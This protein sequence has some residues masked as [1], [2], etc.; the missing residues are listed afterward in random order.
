MPYLAVLLSTILEQFVASVGVPKIESFSYRSLSV[1]QTQQG[2]LTA[3]A[4]VYF[5]APDR[6]REDS[7]M[8]FGQ[9]VTIRRGDESWAETPRGVSQ[10]TPDQH[11]RTVERLYRNYLGLLW[12]AA[13]GRVEVEEPDSGELVLR[14]EGLEMHASFDDDTGHLLEISMLGSNLGG[15]PVTEKRV[16]SDFDADSNLPK[17]VTV[18]QDDALA[19]KITIKTWSINDA[20]SAELFE[21]PE[22]PEER[23]ERRE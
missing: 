14:I 2:E 9:I 11:R 19:A 23:S 18:Y 1:V 3:L 12:A 5:V 17:R 8:S 13:D 4:Q 16:F 7:S 10:L 22:D 20:P 6:Y 21:R 15:T